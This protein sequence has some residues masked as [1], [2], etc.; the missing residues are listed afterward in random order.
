[1]K[2]A[3][4]HKCGG[5]DVLD[6]EAIPSSTLPSGHILIK[7]LAAGLNHLNHY[8]R[9]RLIWQIRGLAQLMPVDGDR[10]HDKNT[11]V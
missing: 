11:P 2:A 5:V 9:A 10:G 3:V 7:V 8:I 6:S 1:M 4:I